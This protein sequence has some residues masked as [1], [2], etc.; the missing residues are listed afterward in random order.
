MSSNYIIFIN[1][2]DLFIMLHLE[3]TWSIW[4]HKAKFKHRKPP[5]FYQFQWHLEIQSLGDLIYIS[6]NFVSLHNEFFTW[7]HRQLFS[8]QVL[9]CVSKRRWQHSTGGF[10]RAEL[11][12]DRVMCWHENGSQ[13][14]PAPSTAAHILKYCVGKCILPD[15]QQWGQTHIN[16]IIRRYQDSPRPHNEV[17]VDSLWQKRCLR[18]NSI[19]HQLSIMH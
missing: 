6:V 18:W 11:H 15:H 17:I 9:C 19:R 7:F 10:E 1:N 2:D 3:Q 16:Q 14:Q 13:N 4:H 5:T 8:L 12:T